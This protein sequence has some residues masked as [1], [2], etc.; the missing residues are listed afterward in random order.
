MQLQFN[1]KEQKLV[2]TDKS[3]VASSS[4]D[5]L[6]ISVVTEDSDWFNADK[7]YAEFIQGELKFKVILT[8]TALDTDKKYK[9]DGKVPWEILVHAK[10]F[11]VMLYAVKETETISQRIT[12]NPEIIEV[13]ESSYSDDCTSTRKPSKDAFTEVWSK[14]DKAPSVTLSTDDVP[15]NSD[16]LNVGDLWFKK[17]GSKNIIG[18]FICVDKT[19]EN[20]LTWKSFVP[21][22]PTDIPKITIGTNPTSTKPAANAG[23]LIFTTEGKGFVCVA[24]GEAGYSNWVKIVNSDE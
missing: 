17:D 2:R 21:T 23:D 3:Q 22:T 8:K 12:T 19:S 14:L 24:S 20:N 1:L 5:Y 7:V 18:T 15:T 11:Q 6:Y 4:K 10:R 16:K 9:F 13:I